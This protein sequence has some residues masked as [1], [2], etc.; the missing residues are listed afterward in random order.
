MVSKVLLI[1]THVLSPPASIVQYKT[2]KY[3]Q[4]C[5][6]TPMSFYCAQGLAHAFTS[7]YGHAA[8][9]VEKAYG[10]K[11]ALAEYNRAVYD[12][13]TIDVLKYFLETSAGEQYISNFKERA[14]QLV[15]VCRKNHFIMYVIS[16]ATHD[17]CLPLVLAL[18][19]PVT[20]SRIINSEMCNGLVKPQMDSYVFT[21]EYI[22]YRES[23]VQNNV[24]RPVR[25]YYVS[26]RNSDLD[27]VK[28][29]RAWFGIK[30]DPAYNDL[31]DIGRFLMHHGTTPHLPQL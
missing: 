27:P 29:E 14:K 7:Y 21:E 28:N 1:D 3:V 12:K 2:A 17:W 11:N 5:T 9:G 24:V 19:L 23:M 22:K 8:I 18:G 31:A 6:P 4:K 16:D 13:D 30:Y 10:V 25:I 15:E 26:D 20:S